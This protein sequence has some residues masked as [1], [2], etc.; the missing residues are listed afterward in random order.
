MMGD[1]KYTVG[2]FGG[3]TEFYCDGRR[4]T[5]RMVLDVLNKP[6]P[7]PESLPT[8]DALADAL[9]K[10]ARKYDLDAALVATLNRAAAALRSRQQA[11]DGFERVAWQRVGADGTPLPIFVS[12]GENLSPVCNYRDVF[13]ASKGEK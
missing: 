3:V 10:L 1:V 2:Q 7:S 11:A 12:L 9:L 5:Y 4:M 6:E 8:G 13:A